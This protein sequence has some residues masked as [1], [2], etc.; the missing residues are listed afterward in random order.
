[1]FF[2]LPGTRG[3]IPNLQTLPECLQNSLHRKQGI[4][5]T[6]AGNLTARVGNFEASEDWP[7]D[8]MITAI[9]NG[10]FYPGP[11]FVA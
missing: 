10:P 5:S 9:G 7:I 6:R 11:G 1:M 2:V 4:I 3:Y 8:P